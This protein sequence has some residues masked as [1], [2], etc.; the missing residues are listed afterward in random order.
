MAQGE[1]EA[2]EAEEVEEWLAQREGRRRLA[3]RT[4][5]EKRLRDEEEEEEEEF[6][7]KETRWITI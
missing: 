4:G 1:G 3:G 6:T 2:E 5:L 7:W